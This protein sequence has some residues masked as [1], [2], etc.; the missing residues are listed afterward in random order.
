MRRHEADLGKE[1][2]G[3]QYSEGETGTRGN[4]VHGQQASSRLQ[5]GVCSFAEYPK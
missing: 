5:A 4:Y 2:P 1:R 3:A